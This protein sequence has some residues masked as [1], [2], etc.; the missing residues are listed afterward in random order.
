[1][2]AKDW[3]IAAQRLTESARLDPKVGTLINLAECEENLGLVAAA[4]QHLQRAI[5]LAAAQRDDRLDLAKTRLVAIDKRVP[6]LTIV[7]APTGKDA[8]VKR[9]DVE[10]G[11]GSI[12]APLPVEPGKHVITVSADGH[13]DRTFEITLAE[14][15]QQSIDVDVGPEGPGSLPAPA[16]GE[17]QESSSSSMKTI[18]FVVGGVGLAGVGVG[19]V[20]GLIALNKHSESKQ[21]CD[22][23]NENLCDQA[24]VDARNDARAAG[25]V[26]TAGF[27]VGGVALATG[28][29]LVLFAPSSTK[30]SRI[31]PTLGGLVLRGT[32]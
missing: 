26:A 20:F 10:L 15:A 8:R 23:T 22:P 2:A 3:K 30:S 32:F 18:G 7:L 16:G 6:R 9:D 28:I 31:S 1:M 29:A 4:R 21:S 14:G 11:A 13:V 24:G 27:V 17:P 19:S 25:N 5:D 12:G